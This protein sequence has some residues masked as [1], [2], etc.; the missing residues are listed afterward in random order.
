MRRRSFVQIAGSVVAVA[1]TGAATGCLGSDVEATRIA[2]AVEDSADID[3][4]HYE[5]DE[6]GLWMEFTSRETLATS[7]SVIGG[8][9]AEIVEA[10]DWDEDMV[11]GEVFIVDEDTNYLFYILAEWARD[12]NAGEITQEEYVEYIEDTAWT[13]E[14]WRARQEDDGDGDGVDEDGGDEIDDEVGDDREDEV[15]DTED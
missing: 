10:F 7:Y 12:L 14:E 11:S 6:D 5:V 15:Q 1:G 4:D 9:Y 2:E 8:A 13:E 3:V